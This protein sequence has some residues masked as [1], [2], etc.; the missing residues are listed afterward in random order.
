MLSKNENTRKS[1]PIQKDGAA[2]AAV[3]ESFQNS[4]PISSVPMKNRLV[5][6]LASPE[7]P[8]DLVMHNKSFDGSTEA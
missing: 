1:T 6:F 8:V 4:T 7:T 5:H 2:A 3:D